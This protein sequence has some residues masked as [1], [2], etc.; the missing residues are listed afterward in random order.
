MSR[1]M[2]TYAWITLLRFAIGKFGR[3]GGKGSAEGRVFFVVV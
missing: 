2:K 3:D 1:R